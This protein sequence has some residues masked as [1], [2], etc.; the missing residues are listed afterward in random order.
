M[1]NGT[2]KPAS[3]LNEGNAIREAYNDVTGVLG[4][5]GWLSGFVG[6]KV[7]FDNDAETQVITFSENGVTLYELTLIY[8]DATQDVLVSAERTA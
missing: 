6:R 7:E 3:N 4:T 2:R 5:E 1:S 8:E